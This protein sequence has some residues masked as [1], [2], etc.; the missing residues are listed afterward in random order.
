M[1]VAD[2]FAREMA[3]S[4]L[5]SGRLTAPALQRGFE[6]VET[7]HGLMPVGGM[8]RRQIDGVRLDRLLSGWFGGLARL[9]QT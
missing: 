7:T 2:A 3:L 4:R 5:G 8:T 6:S 9:R 1:T